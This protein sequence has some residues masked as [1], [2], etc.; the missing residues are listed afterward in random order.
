MTR[1]AVSGEVLR[2]ARDRSGVSGSELAERF[3][4]MAAWETGAAQPTLHQLEA[5]AKKTL[6]PL[7]FFFLP[8]P[9]DV[10]LPI[11][12]YRTL[13]EG[14]VPRPSP[15][16]LETVFTML[17]RQAWMRDYL[18]DEGQSPLAVVGS[19]HIG[20]EPR[21]IAGDIRQ[22][23]G[24]TSGWASRHRTW[25]DALSGLMAAA[26]HAKIMVMANG[27]VG[28][29]THR[30]LDPDEFRGFVLTDDF[31]PLVFMNA[32]DFKSAQMFTLAHELAHVWFGKSAAFD[33]RGMQPA[34]DRMEQACDRVAAEFLVPEA[35]LRR[36][37]PSFANATDPYDD[38][39]RHFK[40]S[41]IVGARRVLDIGL[42]ERPQ[43]LEFYSKYRDDERRRA[44][45]R[46]SG[47]DFYANQN[48]RVGRSFA[49]A[50]LRAVREGRLLYGDAYVLTGLRGETFDR[51]ARKL[52]GAAQK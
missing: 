24:V 6:T 28:N 46:P 49:T 43:F 4:D 17:Q 51:Y 9:P 20:D 29:D 35:E 33:L 22:A 23:L 2:W 41:S 5:F 27:I 39:A 45:S 21:R 30:K 36:A 38:L 12:N 1:V 19:A 32:A 13:S 50:V 37:W 47:G 18:I 48:H 40:V 44:A 42:V 16:L 10:Q 8:S 25:T 14:G 11:P 15:N 3:P 7:G 52:E 34:A 26:E 31:A